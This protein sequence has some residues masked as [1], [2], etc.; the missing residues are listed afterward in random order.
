MVLSMIADVTMTSEVLSLVSGI[1]PL[2]LLEG[3][4]KVPS[5]DETEAMVWRSRLAPRLGTHLL[6]VADNYQQR[7]MGTLIPTDTHWPTALGVLGS[8]QPYLL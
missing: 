4:G 5:L 7:G 3:D 6:S 8:R 1:E 2:S